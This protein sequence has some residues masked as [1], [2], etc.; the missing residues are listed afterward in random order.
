MKLFRVISIL[1]AFFALI[2]NKHSYILHCPY[3]FQGLDRRYQQSLNKHFYILV[4]DPTTTSF[5]VVK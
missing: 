3:H 1:K 2:Y 4:V 5:R